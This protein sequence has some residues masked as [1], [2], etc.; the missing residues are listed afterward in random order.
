MTVKEIEAMLIKE[1]VEILILNDSLEKK[2]DSTTMPLHDLGGFDSHNALEVI[3]SLSEK[4]GVEVETEVFGLSC[5]GGST[6]LNTISEIAE[7]I[8]KSISE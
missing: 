2:P 7:N 6:N 3:V 5:D 4:L 1:I 8:S